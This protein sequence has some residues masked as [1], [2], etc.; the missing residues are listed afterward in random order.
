MKDCLRALVALGASCG[1]GP[2]AATQVAIC[3]DSGRAVLELAD[4]AAPQ[5]VANFL[6]YVD[7]GFYAGTVFH[8]VQAGLFVQG[9]GVDRGLRLRS[10]LPPVPNESSNGLHNTRGSIAAARTEDPD[11]ARSQFFVN[12]GDN[13]QLDGGRDPG[14]TVFGNV[15]EGMEVFEQIGRLPTGSSGPFRADVPTPLVAI[16]SIARVD[17]AAL[18][19]LPEDGREAALKDKIAAAAAA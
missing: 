10:T 7:M 12:L 17:E 16:R 1:A 14:Y 2:L 13:T 11:S 9:G 15:T 6:R 3:T 4:E 19:E 8:R 5:Q 18:A